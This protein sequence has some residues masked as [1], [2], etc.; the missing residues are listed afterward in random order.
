MNESYSKAKLYQVGKKNYE[1]LTNYCE[2][3]SNEGYWENPESIL[4]RNVED[5]LGFYVQAILIQVA[6]SCECLNQEELSF[7]LDIPNIDAFNI[8]NTDGD[9][10]EGILLSE[11]VLKSPPILLQ[12]CSLRDLEKGSYLSGLFL[13]S[14]LNIMLAM[15][16]LNHSRN[17]VMTSF[18]MKYYNQVSI[19]ISS[20][21]TNI[22]SER[23]VFRKLSCEDIELSSLFLKPYAQN[24]SSDISKFTKIR[25]TVT[26]ENQNAMNNQN[27]K[28]EQQEQGNGLVD[29]V[30]LENREL[31]A[32][33]REQQD[34]LNR[35]L[36]D[37]NS[38]VG[39]KAVKDEI[40]SLINVI[41]VKKLREEYNMP[42]F[43]LSYHMVYTGNP[44]TGKTTIAR[45]VAQ[46]Y[47]EL[48]ILSK[49]NL[50]ETDR[51]GLVAGYVGQTALK[52]KEVVDQA[53]GGVLF[54]DEAY[55]LSNNI[56][57]SDFGGEAIDAL[58]KLMEDNR[59]DLVVIVA[60]YKEEMKQ[61]L[62]ANTGLISRFNRF[63]EFEDYSTEELLQIL[64]VMAEKFNLTIEKDALLAV[65]KR[66]TDMTINERES[67]GNA[68]GIR[69]LFEK[70]LVNQANRIVN[71]DK[72]TKEQLSVIVLE[73]VTT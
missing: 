60:G 56:G 13:D 48:G 65:K 36:R 31:Q 30:Q 61:F 73:D 2:I 62:N 29:R 25:N 63:I 50:V 46:I 53:I 52:V 32:V 34:N 57:S 9:L 42:V 39:L 16:D 18:L 47:K 59:E 68:R 3:L 33:E 35:L 41:K 10:K 17:R 23:D 66:I 38:L 24:S 22:I 8:R 64:N 1:N 11:K 20:N 67:F 55:S 4:K 70:I 72:P 37:L 14:L 12:L 44:G 5:M 49:G 45:L 21:N 40:N 19:F 43:N 58:V 15:A 28:L 27:G 7:I 26:Q 54:I 51:G 71:Y 69:N 6:A